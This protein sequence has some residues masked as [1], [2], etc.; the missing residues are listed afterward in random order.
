MAEE[1]F[2]SA[3]GQ[4]M[5]NLYAGEGKVR[6]ESQIHL[7]EYKEEAARI[8]R[9]TADP[10]Q[11]KKSLLPQGQSL[12]CEIEGVLSLHVLYETARNGEKGVVSSY[13][14]KE[15]FTYSF[16]IPLHGEIETE[17]LLAMTE[18]SVKN[19]S[20]KLSGP[21]SLAV[22]C[23]VIVTTDVRGNEPFS[24]LGAAPSPDVI[25]K[26]ETM[27]IARLV[28]VVTE[29]MTLS[30]TIRLPKAYLPIEEIC[31]LEVSLM[32]R[33]V[34]CQEG[35]IRFTALC[36]L[37]CSYRAKGE[38]TFI[39]FYQP[40]ELDRSL[41][42]ETVGEGLFADVRLIPT[43]LQA[44]LDIDEE[45]EERVIPFELTFLCESAV[46]E[47]S[48]THLLEDAFSTKG[49]L[50]VE[51]TETGLCGL[52]GISDFSATV[53]DRISV[54]A[55]GILRAEGICPAVEFENSYLEEGKLCLEGKIR[56]AFL[57]VGQE[58]ELIPCEESA[59]FRICPVE[60]GLKV[61][62]AEDCTIEVYGSVRGL[63]IDPDGDSLRLRYDLCGSVVVYRNA[64]KTIL[65]A[66]TRGKDYP[67]ED[68]VLFIYPE[69][70]ED[71]WSLAKTYHASP[72]ALRK[73]NA[74]DDGP[75]PTYLKILR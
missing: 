8:I 22:R 1:V 27:E 75:L 12:L 39:S 56:F 46:F 20:A 73:T 54:K 13:L 67:K 60:I 2:E 11:L 16:K 65:S 72:D 15:N 33:G 64:K 59:P 37:N 9:V 50:E 6:V 28:N 40:I 4:K 3:R 74:L 44:S 71:L 70:G 49:E 34:K 52:V 31:E 51:K 42:I 69:K 23:D 62:E 48:A 41:G 57:G 32:A 66:L 38:D 29:E 61:P 25:V 47:N 35:G 17:P 58:G 18:F 53:K 7:P 19:V 26:G 36:D 43:A 63:E 68:G 10:K 45:G 14:A 21:R 5:A 55:E 24:A 30:E